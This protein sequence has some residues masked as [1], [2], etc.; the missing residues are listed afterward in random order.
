MARSSLLPPESLAALRELAAAAPEGAS[1]LMTVYQEQYRPLHQL[2]VTPT[3]RI[4]HVMTDTA[5][6]GPRAIKVG[7]IL[8]DVCFVSLATKSKELAIHWLKPAGIRKLLGTDR[9]VVRVPQ[10][11]PPALKEAMEKGQLSIG[12]GIPSEAAAQHVFKELGPLIEHC[13]VIPRP[14]RSIIYL[15][16]TLPGGQRRWEFIETPLGEAVETWDLREV[17]VSAPQPLSIPIQTN[18]TVYQAEQTLFDV[19]LPFVENVSN[20]DLAKILQDEMDVLLEFR[21]ALRSVINNASLEG[22]DTRQIVAD[23]VRPKI[24]N[25]ERRFNHIV[26]MSRL[27]MAGAMVSTAALS[28]VSYMHTGLAQ[29][30]VP[31]LGAGGLAYGAQEYASRSNQLQSLKDEPF[32]LL[33][34]LGRLKSGD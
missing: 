10:S 24:A 32:Y 2:E 12:F 11:P 26:N 13:G 5:E 29:A 27:K 22:Q 23:L 34:K 20:D 21:A 1:R 9:I 17:N 25:V 16:E 3:L 30:V 28:L 15:K 14:A 19:T 33:W 7:A 8:N 31:L 6:E 4:G 18:Q